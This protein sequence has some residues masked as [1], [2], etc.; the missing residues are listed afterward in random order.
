MWGPLA[1]TVSQLQGQ[2]IRALCHSDGPRQDAY[3]STGGRVAAARRRGSRRSQLSSIN[4]GAGR[5][6]V[7]AAL[8][9]FGLTQ[10][11]RLDGFLDPFLLSSAVICRSGHDGSRH[12]RKEQRFH[13]CAHKV[14]SPLCLFCHEPCNASFPL[15]A[16]A[17]DRRCTHF[18]PGRETSE[19]SSGFLIFRQCA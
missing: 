8:F 19:E 12:E 17:A 7:L 13:C 3:A 15:T 16:P 18:N 2:R 6:A 4:P 1:R 11:A 9:P 5:S 14:W 10:H